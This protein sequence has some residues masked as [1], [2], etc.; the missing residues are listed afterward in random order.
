MKLVTWNINGIKARHARVL[1]WVQ[2]KRPDVLC[3]QELKSEDAS[4]LFEPFRALGYDVALFGQKAYN[5]VGILSRQPLA[6]VRR[7]FADE[8]E[9]DPQARLLTA[10]A[11]GLRVTCAYFPNGE[12]TTSDK[13]RYKLSWM[14]RLRDRLA[15]DLRERREAVLCGDFN[16]APEDV[17]VHDP[18]AWRGQVL[19]TDEEKAA[20]AAI[21]EAGLVDVV[22]RVQPEG[23]LFTW[24]DYRMRGFPR[25][26]GLRIDHVYATP[27][28]AERV[29][30]A[31]VDRE[32]RGGETPSDHAPLTVELREG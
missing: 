1:A 10:T 31:E 11:F 15:A 23:Q 20:L 25:N 29:V 19:F 4:A 18:K 2:A 9:S 16:V 22:R 6:D 8:G 13:F 5:G 30:A 27:P 21:R 7:G 14:K 28:V 17:D 26:L 12:S 3:L 32:E 24:W